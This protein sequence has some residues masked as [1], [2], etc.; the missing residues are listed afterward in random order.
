MSVGIVCSWL[1]VYKCF[2]CFKYFWLWNIQIVL[3]FFNLFV[4]HFSIKMVEPNW[5]LD[6]ILCFPNLYLCNCSLN[7]I[8]HPLIYTKPLYKPEVLS[9][10]HYVNHRRNPRYIFRCHYIQCSETKSIAWGPTMYVNIYPCFSIASMNVTITFLNCFFF[11]ST[12]QIIK[13]DT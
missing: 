12:W 2:T 3:F 5:P 11:P 1:L 7:F 8:H 13:N 6:Q 9:H 10:V 4:C